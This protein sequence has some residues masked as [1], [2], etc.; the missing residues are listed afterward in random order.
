MLTAPKKITDKIDSL[1]D[2]LE[3]ISAELHCIEGDWDGIAN[4]DPNTIL[5][6]PKDL[7]KIETHLKKTA[8]LFSHLNSFIPDWGN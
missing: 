1:Q 8:K 4:D 7:I 6:I 2:L 3:E 5:Q